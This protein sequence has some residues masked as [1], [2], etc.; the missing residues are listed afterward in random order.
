MISIWDESVLEIM[1]IQI[2]VTI[3]CGIQSFYVIRT[4]FNTG[5]WF[6]IV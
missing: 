5:Y 3:H 1:T 2:A 6:T 4:F